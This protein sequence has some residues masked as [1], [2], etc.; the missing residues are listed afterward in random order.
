MP[1]PPSV[2]P[3]DT[4]TEIAFERAAIWLAALIVIEIA[5]LVCLVSPLIF[6][7][8]SRAELR[9]VKHKSPMTTEA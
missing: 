8:S 2:P 3:Q 1:T 6:L 7:L 5:L 4:R 9:A